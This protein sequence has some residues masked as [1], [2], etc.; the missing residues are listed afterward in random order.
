MEFGSSAVGSV[1]TVRAVCQI[2]T[3]DDDDADGTTK[4]IAQSRC[5]SQSR[6]PHQHHRAFRFQI[7]D[8]DFSIE[9]V[10]RRTNR[11]NLY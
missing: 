5:A 7:S 3:Y 9:D 8:S 2:T 6:R 10:D 4:A 1:S 11:C